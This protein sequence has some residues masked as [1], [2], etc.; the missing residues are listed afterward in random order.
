MI[1]VATVGASEEHDEEERGQEHGYGG[2][3]RTG[4]AIADVTGDGADDDYW[5]GRDDPECDAIHELLL[6]EPAVIADEALVQKRH[7]G[8]ARAEGERSGLQEKQAK[9]SE[10]GSRA[11]QAQPFDGG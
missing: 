7:D 5:A 4:E 6:A 3:K 1:R 8:E 9:C 11:G 10:S 2:D